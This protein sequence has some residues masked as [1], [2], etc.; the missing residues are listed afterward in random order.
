MGLINLYN[1]SKSFGGDIV[2]DS[3]SLEVFNKDRIALI[4]RNG[5]GKTTLFNIITGKTAFD[6]G[7]LHINDGLTVSYLNQIP[8]EQPGRIAEDVIKTAFDDIKA[9]EVQLNLAYGKMKQNPE[10]ST[11]IKEYGELHDKF[12][13]LGGYNT[14]EKYS[15]IIKG[16]EIPDRILKSSFSV[17]SGGEKTTIMLA[18]VLLSGPDILLLDEPTN[19]LDMDA[20]NWLESYMSDYRGTIIF[21]SHDRY[22]I[23]RAANRVAEIENTKLVLY[24]GNF[25]AYKKEKT[26]RAERNLKLYERQQKELGRLNETVMRM[27]NYATPKTIHIAKTI[28]SRINRI[29]IIEKAVGESKMH[30]T[31][32]STGKTGKE[33]LRAN[34]ISKSFGENEL[35]KDVD[36]LIRSGERVAVIGP[37]GAGKSTFVKILIGEIKPDS[38]DIKKGSNVKYAYLEQDVKFSHDERTVL[39]EVCM[40]LDLPM[41]SARSLL[42]KYLFSGDDVF[43]QLGVLSGGEKSR[44]RLLLEMRE[45]VNLLI[46]D[47]PTNHLDIASREE[48]ERAISDFEGT[49]LFISHDRQFINNFAD[50]VFEIRNSE[51]S[52][53]NGNYDHYLE[54]FK[55]K[56]RVFEPIVKKVIKPNRGKSK[57]KSVYTLRLTEDRIAELENELKKIENDIQQNAT[58]YE[59]LEELSMILEKT[60]SELDNTYIKWME[61]T[62]EENC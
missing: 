13:F 1:I 31:I 16:L 15:R 29:D 45:S 25:T 7:E 32:E 59:K 22:F 20:V 8:P 27:K 62:D 11:L 49:M 5:T 47:E 12:E 4:G 57:R 51:F 3:V 23:D 53:Y 26:D 10:N 40:E 33:V 37:N 54:C 42:G 9:V 19:H 41:S 58:D 34:N 6:E 17:L 50:I 55:E 2:L 46:L 43:K 24:K 60:K 56:Q 14:A 52:I 21:T 38:G 44:L 28:E 35:F 39:E 18:K 61:M 48:L 36:F 30:L